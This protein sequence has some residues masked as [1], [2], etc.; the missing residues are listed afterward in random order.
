MGDQNEEDDQAIADDPTRLPIGPWG[1]AR[2]Q[3]AAGSISFECGKD[4]LLWF[5][6]GW[7]FAG[8]FL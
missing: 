5:Q 6:E 4:V 3:P 2:I 1:E 8:F 7:H